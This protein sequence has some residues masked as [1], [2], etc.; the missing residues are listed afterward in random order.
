MDHLHHH[1]SVSNL[2]DIVG[3]A[4]AMTFSFLGSLHCAGMCTPLVC[5]RLGKRASIFSTSIWFYNM[6]RMFSYVGTGF[7]AG[8]IGR[9]ITAISNIAGPFA[10]ILG[11]VMILAGIYRLIKSGTP[12]LK[13]SFNS[14]D[15]KFPRTSDFLFGMITVFLPCASLA[16]A[17]IAAAASGTPLGGGFVMAGF[18]TGTLPIM[19]LSPA[20]PTLVA[21]RMSAKWSRL[22]GPAFL[23]FAGCIT[24]A[25]VWH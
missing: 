23:I 14:D 4:A 2:L 18:F 13:M 24:L 17:F 3:F 11:S 10:A 6:G 8:T 21:N 19:I 12:F 1:H 7:V 15:V 9:E 16:P 5:A 22:A 25:R 20:F